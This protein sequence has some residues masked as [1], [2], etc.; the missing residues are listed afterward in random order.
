MSYAE[1]AISLIMA[2]TDEYLKDIGRGRRIDDYPEL[3]AA[4]SSLTDEALKQWA[5]VSGAGWRERTASGDGGRYLHALELLDGDT[6]LQTL[7][8][9]CLAEFTYPVFSAYLED[10]F[11]Y[12]P[13]LHLAAMIEGREPLSH[14]EIQRLAVTARRLLVVD[15]NTEPLQY[16][17]VS[18]DER[19]MGFIGGYD[20]V[21]RRL[22]DFTVLYRPGDALHDAF[23]NNDLIERGVSY[24]RS[25]GRVLTLAGCG[26]RRFI[27]RH[28][29]KGLDRGFLFLNIADLIRVADRGDIA[30]LRDTLLREAYFDEAGICLYGFSDRFITGGISDRVRGRHDMEVLSGQLITPLT[31]EGIP[32]ILC[33]DEAKM[34]PDRLSD[35]I[36]CISLPGTYS[37]E[38]R[39]TLWQGFFEM[40]G[41][42]LEAASFASRY[43]MYPREVS[44]AVKNYMALSAS[45]RKGASGSGSP[46][47]G[48]DQ[49]MQSKE[50]YFA[51]INIDSIKRSE[52]EMGRIVYPDIRLEDV[53]LKDNVKRVLRDAVNA[54]LTGPLVMDEWG[55]KKSYPYGRGVSLLMAGPPGTGKTMSANAIAGELS[56]PLY[57]VNLSNTVDKYIGETEKNLEKAFSFAEK[58]NTILFFDEA[59]AL[60]GTRSEVHDSKDRYANTEISYLLQRME[61]YDGIVVMATNI[62]G[63]IDPAFMRRI[64]FVAHFE[65]PD[66][67]MRRAIWESC[68]TDE[69]PHDE[70]DL[71]YLASQFDKFTGSIIKTVF[72]NACVA[73]AGDGGRLT[74]KHLIYA[75]KQETEKESAVGFTMDILGKYAYLV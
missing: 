19:L 43:R 66:E 28:I 31:D 8:E 36:C 54:V 18:A 39:K 41:L 9:L 57:Q 4:V 46:D 42:E 32:V 72:L 53:K 12:G 73:A 58:N 35:G 6:V 59:D 47:S 1:T 16:A 69:V 62:K 22:S 40:Y 14:D 7:M 34:M 15:I 64:R 74:M 11:G 67:E 26:G 63:N 75:I 61:A 68:I 29:A 24:F 25:G 45:D 33:A 49:P 13:C 17:R 21:S 20:G 10:N 50:E 60:F 55:L 65:N 70:I 23:V 56:L 37:F 38:E 44:Y 27:A 51:R 71:D 3:A 52:L 2:R 48:A 5:M 30:P